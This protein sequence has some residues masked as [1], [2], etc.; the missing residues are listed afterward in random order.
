MLRSATR[1]MGLCEFAIAS[2]VPAH[3]AADALSKERRFG[4]RHL[5]I[6]AR[7]DPLLHGRGTRAGLTAEILKHYTSAWATPA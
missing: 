5:T 3:A 1:R 7:Y 2:Q 4:K 6:D